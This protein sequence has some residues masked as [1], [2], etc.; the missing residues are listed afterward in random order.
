MPSPLDEPS[1]VEARWSS[2]MARAQDGDREAYERLMGELWDAVAGYLGRR[3]GG[4]GASDFVAECVQESL[5]AVHRAR[6]T[7]DPGRAFRPWLFTIVRHKAIDLLRRQQVRG[8]AEPVEP[9][10][11]HGGVAAEPVDPAHALDGAA[12]LAGLDPIYREALVL[13]KLRGLTLEEAA[14]R[15]GVSVSAMKT[16]VHRAVRA[17]RKALRDEDL[18]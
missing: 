11:G 2:W 7:Y 12:L 8:H 6:R 18:A 17:V 1:D 9:E 13:T 10:A 16:R 4:A 3:F 14:R 15:A 5:L